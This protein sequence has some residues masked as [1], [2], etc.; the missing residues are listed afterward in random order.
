MSKIRTTAATFTAAMALG[1]GSF[2]GAAPAQAAGPC[3]SKPN[4]YCSMSYAKKITKNLVPGNRGSA[5]K[6]LQLALIQVRIPVK[7]SGVF[8]AQ[9]TRAV[10]TYQASRLI[11]VTGNAGPSTRNALR[12]GAGDK[13][14]KK[15][16]SVSSSSKGHKAVNFAATQIGKPYR[17]GA[18]GPSSYD[19]S[20]LTGA[21]WR[22]AGK[23]IPRTSQAQWRG[24]KS[25]SKSNLRPGDVVVFYGG[26]HVG[27]YAGNGY[28]VHAP[29][30]GKR[31]SKV[32]MSTMPFSGAVRP[33]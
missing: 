25:V 30:T 29:S 7:A 1:A 24:L 15:R 19:C 4:V 13:A 2:A 31:I 6:Q 18:T 17:Y 23:P 22:A 3:S 11:S 9:T 5:V 16:V 33:A 27:L 21:A 12:K 32:K 26:G 28:V 20:G 10:K 8:D 14:P